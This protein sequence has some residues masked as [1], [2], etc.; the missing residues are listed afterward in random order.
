MELTGY[1][2]TKIDSQLISRGTPKFVGESSGEKYIDQ[3]KA[4][5][6]IQREANVKI[7]QQEESKEISSRPNPFLKSNMEIKSNPFQ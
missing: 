3:I 1:P 6:V 7:L 5:N 4:S 2:E